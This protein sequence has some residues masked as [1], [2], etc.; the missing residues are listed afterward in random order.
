MTVFHLYSL[1]VSIVPHLLILGIFFFIFTN[2]RLWNITSLHL[3]EFSLLMASIILSQFIGHV[4]PLLWNL[5]FFYCAVYLSVLDIHASTKSIVTYVCCKYLLLVLGLYFHS[6]WT[7]L[8]EPN[9]S[10]L[11]CSQP[12]LYDLCFCILL[13]KISPIQRS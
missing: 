9:F 3:I 6:L 1:S 10:I 4:F 7:L 12:L 11:M 8:N 2:L 13:K 5:Y